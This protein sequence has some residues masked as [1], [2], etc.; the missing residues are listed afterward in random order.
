ML[1][2]EQPLLARNELLLA[3]ELNPYEERSRELAR[4][5]GAAYER[6]VVH[7]DDLVLLGEEHV[8]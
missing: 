3:L 7:R 2:D 8:G 6:E 1:L 4:E 5:L